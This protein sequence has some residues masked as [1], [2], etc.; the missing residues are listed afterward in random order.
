MPN[1]LQRT[2]AQKDVPQNAYDQREA[3]VAIVFSAL[4]LEA[5]INEVGA[6]AAAVPS[7]DRC[8]PPVFDKLGEVLVN[9]E[10]SRDSTLDKFLLAK[11]I[12]SG[13]SYDKSR[14][15][16][17][18]FKTLIDLRNALAHIKHAKR[19]FKEL[20]DLFQGDISDLRA[21]REFLERAGY[22]QEEFDSLFEGLREVG[23]LRK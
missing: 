19:I 17:Q 6:L 10:E 14:M 7:S 8:D 21:L 11:Q 22:S 4:T 2:I 13:S 12:L 18:S 5:F 1:T 3:I 15:P 16:Y 9:E 20:L 23:I